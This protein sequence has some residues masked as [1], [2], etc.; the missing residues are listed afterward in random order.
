MLRNKDRIYELLGVAVPELYGADST[1]PKCRCCSVPRKI[2]EA[3]LKV[4]A[5]EI[6]PLP[7]AE[8]SSS[9]RAGDTP[10]QLKTVKKGAWRKIEL[11]EKREQNSTTAKQSLPLR[12][13]PSSPAKPT[14][15]FILQIYGAQGRLASCRQH[16]GSQCA[17][18]ELADYS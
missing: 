3:F 17:G 6:P 13:G 2:A 5:L 7:S 11:S 9:E 4:P 18:T 14:R 8:F 16:Q 15:K 1:Q 12:G 10:Y